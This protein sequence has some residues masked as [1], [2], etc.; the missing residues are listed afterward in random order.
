M[1]NNKK[2]EKGHLYNEIVSNRISQI[3]KKRNSEGLKKPYITVQ[4]VIY[5][6]NND[7]PDVIKLAS[8]LKVDRVN[9]IRP[10]VKFNACMAQPWKDRLRIYRLAEKLGRELHIRIDM[11]EYAFFSGYKRFLWK[12]FN[13]LFGFNNWCPRLYDFVYIT[14]K[15][16]VTPCCELPRYI[17]GDLKTQTLEEIWNGKKMNAYRNNHKKICKDCHIYKIKV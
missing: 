12:Y 9:L 8:T 3:I 4:Q 5:K 16:E 15:G 17:V 6:G 1:V 11:F 7:T 13:Q 14:M 2:T 10:Y